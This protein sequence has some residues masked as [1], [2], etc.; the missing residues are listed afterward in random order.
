MNTSFSTAK[1]S[2]KFV[3]TFILLTTIRRKFT[4]LAPHMV[5]MSFPASPSAKVLFA[6]PLGDDGLTARAPLG[7]SDD[8]PWAENILAGIDAA[9]GF[10]TGDK[11]D[12]PVAASAPDLRD[13][14]DY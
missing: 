12:A 11:A 2:G 3:L 7:I 4:F 8:I 5:T 13:K 6:R 14:Q 10:I 1:L 9:D